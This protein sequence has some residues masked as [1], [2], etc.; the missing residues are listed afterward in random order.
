MIGIQVSIGNT[1]KVDNGCHALSGHVKV[2]IKNGLKHRLNGPAEIDT[3]KGV[4]TWFKEGKRHRIGGPAVVYKNKP[5]L[6]EYWE[7]GVKVPPPKPDKS[8]KK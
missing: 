5:E 4:E 7:N 2:Y 6:N 3:K 1:P 8:K